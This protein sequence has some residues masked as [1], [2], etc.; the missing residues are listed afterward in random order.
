MRSLTALCPFTQPT[1]AK[2]AMHSELHS[3]ELSDVFTFVLRDA[4]V[5]T[6]YQTSPLE[7]VLIAWQ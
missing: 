2:A 1:P 6:K 4:I 3:N 7:V 5:N